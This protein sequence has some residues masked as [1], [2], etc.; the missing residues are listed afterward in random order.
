MAETKKRKTTTSTQVKAR[1]NKKT[2][3]L[4]TAN[5]PKALAQEFKDKCSVENISQASIIKK[6][7]E[8]FLSE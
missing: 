7:I 5:I 6:A 3:T 1:Y 2:Y 8:N 4:I